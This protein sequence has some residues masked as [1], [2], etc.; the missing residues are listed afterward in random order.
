[1]E[2]TWPGSPPEAACSMVAFTDPA[3]RC[4]RVGAADRRTK[5]QRAR[6]WTAETSGRPHQVCGLTILN[7]WHSR[8]KRTGRLA[9]RA[10]IGAGEPIESFGAGP[11]VS[12]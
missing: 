3:A 11:R 5:G 4:S 10:L 1:M 12:P 9:T 8:L 7:C 2:A 6:R